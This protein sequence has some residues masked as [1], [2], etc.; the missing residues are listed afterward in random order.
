M[1]SS[2]YAA[3]ALLPIMLGPLPQDRGGSLLVELCGGGTLAIDLGKGGDNGNDKL[4]QPCHAKGC[5]A[6]GCRKDGAG[7]AR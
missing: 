7:K 6:G 1:N 4:P 5:H 2:V 3:M